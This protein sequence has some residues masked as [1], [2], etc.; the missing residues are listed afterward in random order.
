MMMKRKIFDEEHEMFRDSVRSF[1]QNE[2][3]PHSDEWHEKGIVDR[4][5]FLKA[6]EQGLLLMWADEK[7]GGAG[8]PDFRYEQVLIEENVRYGDA[9]FFM[10]LHNR[11]VGPYIG[12]LGTEEQK[13]RWLPK[14][15]SGEH[16]LAV[17]ITEP[18]AGSDVASIRT[19][20][21]D[22]GDHWLLNGSKIYTSNGILADLVVV[23]ART[24]PNTRHGL[25]LFVVERGMEGFERGRNLKKMGLKSQDTAEL[26]FNNVK[27]PK[28][29]LLGELNRGFYQLMHFLAEERLLGAVGYLA[30]SNVA[31]DITME[32]IKDRKAFGQ[33]I[34]DFQNTRF[35]MADMRMEIDIAQAFVDQCVLE[36]NEGNLSADD[37]AKAK[38]FT[39]ELEGRVVDACVQLHGGAGY[40]DEYPICR[41]FLNAR[42]S[43]I[44]A[45][46]SEVMREIIAR[47]IG[48]DPRKKQK[49]PVGAEQAA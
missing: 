17:A 31:F 49:K 47:S 22:K 37:A 11:L 42:V 40:M 9:G 5:A 36:H 33:T 44:Y 26:F 7:Y 10:T 13:A 12:E 8:V 29:N 18:G 19:K 21:E 15:I 46:S 45:G 6:G 30:T 4:D 39:S 34:A 3:G 38:L 32:Y 23:V 14:C 16:V 41:M 1:M 20:A 24:D 43:R 35:K 28:E 48:L 25:S 27:V 2:I